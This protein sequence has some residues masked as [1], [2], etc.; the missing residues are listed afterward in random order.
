MLTA[1]VRPP[2]QV[3]NFRIAPGEDEPSAGRFHWGLLLV[4]GK[5]KG[6]GMRP[7]LPCVGE[8]RFHAP[9]DE[10]TTRR[11]VGRPI[12]T[13]KWQRARRAFIAKRTAAAAF[14]GDVLRCE[15][16]GVTLIGKHPAPD[17]P[18]VD[19]IVPDRGDL[20]LFWDEGN[21]QIVSK[22]WHD[23]VKQSR[24]KRGEA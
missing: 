17:S 9:I 4:M 14:L 24:E 3:T 8:R 15:Q 22:E 19:H 11:S 23:R 20:A 6:C 2:R 18:V 5:L 1:K 13:A 12:N 7:M 21:W 10:D 16:T